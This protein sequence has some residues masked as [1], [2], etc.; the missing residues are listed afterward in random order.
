MAILTEDF[1][2]DVLVAGTRFANYCDGLSLHCCA[3]NCIDALS[4]CP[5][6]CVYSGEHTPDFLI[7]IY[8]HAKLQKYL[9]TYS[10]FCSSDCVV[11]LVSYSQ[12]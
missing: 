12:E 11:R 1:K 4:L 6:G 7:I 3:K 10:V 2:S 5:L 8:S 9:H